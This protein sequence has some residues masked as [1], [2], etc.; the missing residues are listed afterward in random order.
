MERLVSAMGSVLLNCTL[1]LTS[2]VGPSA[3][4]G[5]F[6]STLYPYSI[7][8][9]P[10]FQHTVSGTADVFTPGPTSASHAALTV[11]A[12]SGQLP[13]N[14]GGLLRATGGQ[15]VHIDGQLHLA[16]QP[17]PLVQAEFHNLAG[18]Y[19]VVW[20]RFSACG[21]SWSLT[22]TYAAH[23]R[24]LR[25]VMLRMLHSFQLTCGRQERR[26]SSRLKTRQSW[27][28]LNRCL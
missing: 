1:A 24:T 25:S 4:W 7:L 20:A 8:L 14:P 18:S 3:S 11:F 27:K 17:V 6:Q 2:V 15:H 13:A 10:S 26:T 16:G 22:S 28:V 12:T 21:L 9:P 19:G 5:R 23:A